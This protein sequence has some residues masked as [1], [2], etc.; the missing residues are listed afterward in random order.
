M[1]VLNPPHAGAHL[2]DD[3][4]V[5]AVTAIVRSGKLFRYS[6]ESTKS[7]CDRFE[8]AMSCWLGRP[9]YAVN[10]GTAALRAALAAA[11]V[12]P[13]DTVLVSAF[14][15]I[16]SA[17]A[18]LAAGAIPEPLDIGPQLEVDLDDLETKLPG[19]NAIIGVYAPG[20]P[21]NMADVAE[22][23][24][25]A[26]LTFIEDACQA[27]GVSSLGACAGT[28]GDFGAF[29]FQQGKQLCA[30]E[31]GA[32]VANKS[33]LVGVKR[34]ADHGADRG[35]DNRPNWTESDGGYGDNLRMT[36]LQAALLTVQ[37]NRLDLMLDR[38]RLL[39]AAMVSLADG[40]VRLARSLDPDGHSGN[41]LLLIAPTEEKAASAIET[42]R[43][44]GIWLQWAW[45]K[46]FFETQLIRR[47]F[48][49]R[50]FSAPR[51]RNLAGCILT[52]PIPPL[53]EA[54]GN[55]L[56]VAGDRVLNAIGSLWA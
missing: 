47:R 33:N 56:L 32:V 26:G 3:A 53:D 13:G 36:E 31:G 22:R 46:P 55:A 35:F 16:A 42:A 4:E 15:F 8:A 34:F 10:S 6:S 48:P 54:D 18:V 45:Q 14:T 24:R 28:I 52:M 21:S 41:H 23:A 20:H 1:R 38:Q 2:I 30:G 19:A 50:V 37:L 25:N 29:S 27:L 51:A 40:R 39:H 7:A 5:E 43:A 17:S 44:N 11:G 12:G 49:D 9:A